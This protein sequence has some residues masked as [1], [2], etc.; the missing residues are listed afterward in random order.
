MEN[1]ISLSEKVKR[2][3]EMMQSSTPKKTDNEKLELLMSIRRELVFSPGTLIFFKDPSELKA[4]EFVMD[5]IW[6]TMDSEEIWK[7]IGYLFVDLEE[8]YVDRAKKL[9]PI[10]ISINPQNTEFQTYFDEAMKAW[11]FGLNNSAIILCFAILE[12]ILVSEL[13]D[14]DPDLALELKRVDGKEKGVKNKKL[15]ILIKNAFERNLV[16]DREYA[17]LDE[18]RTIRNNCIHH[19][20]PV[21]EQKTYEVIIRTK[22]I[23]EKILSKY[24]FF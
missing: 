3:V 18:L 2:L 8:D 21:E 9:K 7:E 24:D 10:L 19:L 16:D 5:F 22:E 23:V 20:I 13:R 15:A 4:A 14:I 1:Q 17:I 11:L 12:D 6:D